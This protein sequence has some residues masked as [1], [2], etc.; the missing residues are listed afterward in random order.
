M[1]KAQHKTESDKIMGEMLA[2]GVNHKHYPI[3]KRK[4]LAAVDQEWGRI[5]AILNREEQ[6]GFLSG[7][8]E[9]VIDAIERIKT[10]R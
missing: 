2:L 10:R 1:L 3:L 9:K 5:E 8:E 4:W 6:E 7:C